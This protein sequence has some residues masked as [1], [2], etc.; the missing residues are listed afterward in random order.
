MRGGYAAVLLLS[1]L[2]AACVQDLPAAPS[3][4]RGLHD[5]VRAGNLSLLKRQLNAGVDQDMPDPES[6]R[7][8]LMTALVAENPK[9][10]RTL[11]KTGADPARTDS[12]G[13]TAL[14]VA[15]QINEPWRVLDLLKAGAL[16]TARNAQGQTFQRYLFMTQDKLLSR[17]NRKGREAVLQ[18][19]RSH[20]IAIEGDVRVLPEPTMEFR[21]A[22]S[23]LYHV[24]Y[25]RIAPDGT[26]EVSAPSS[27]G[28]ATGR[29]EGADF[30]YVFK[31]GV[32]RFNIGR[33]GYDEM[34]HLLADVVEGKVEPNA[35]VDTA[36]D[37]NGKACLIGRTLDLP[38]MQLEWSGASRGLF[39][40]PK[41]CRSVEGKE[42]AGRL[43]AS[44]RVLA[45]HM[46]HSGQDG[47]IEDRVA[48]EPVPAPFAP[49]IPYVLEYS[50]HNAWT[51]QTLK[52]R[53]EADGT[54]WLDLSETMNF[55]SAGLASHSDFITLAK[56]RHRFAIGAR[57]YGKIRT[58]LEQYISGPKR[59]TSCD[60][61]T[62]TDQPL[63]TLTYEF[64]PHNIRGKIQQNRGC[65]DFAERADTAFQAILGGLP[66]STPN[67]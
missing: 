37:A 19:L 66:L 3:D 62:A 41:S 1:A 63:V 56:G 4:T 67:P 61:T 27:L 14:H 36:P 22:G 21:F 58:A 39:V 53:V 33:P 24:L 47:V 35:L 9:A 26:G 59:D 52:W 28:Y 13:N 57:G 29:E 25:W 45:R 32:H 18:W 30:R 10:F 8:P 6:G 43:V 51:G 49:P 2:L 16:P 7:T 46:L 48:P 20:S 5:T 17:D 11:L 31:G 65:S 44:W 23:R 60:G 34:R 15:A 40:M 38:S 12:V 54:G 64:S 55:P 42:L 50:Q